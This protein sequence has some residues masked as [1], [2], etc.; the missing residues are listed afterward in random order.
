MAQIAP[1]PSLRSGTESSARGCRPKRIKDMYFGATDANNEFIDAESDLF[2]SFFCLYPGFNL[3]DI[4]SGRRYLIHGSKGSGKT[5]LLRYTE[6][7]AREKSCQTRFIKYKRQISSSEKQQMAQAFIERKATSDEVVTETQ[8]HKKDSSQNYVLGW[9]LYLI[10]TIIYMALDCGVSPFDE[11]AGEWA[12]LV[13]LLREIYGTNGK[14]S[15]QKLLP[16]ITRGQVTLGPKFAKLDIVFGDGTAPQEIRA[17]FAGLAE[18]IISLYRS[19]SRNRD[20]LPMYLFI[21]EV[22]LSYGKKKEYERDVRFIG[23]MIE[24]VYTLND[25]AREN[26]FPVHI[27][28]ALREE[29]IR[30]VT[31]VGR[32]LNKA[33]EDRG[34]KINWRRGHDEEDSPLLTVL[35]RRI[36]SNLDPD[37]SRATNIWKSFFPPQVNGIPIK[38]YILDQTWSNPR[39]IVR[40]LSLLKDASGESSVFSEQ[41]FLSIRKEYA[42]L[43]WSEI[44]EEI[45]A[46]KSST[47][48]EGLRRILYGIELPFTLS[49]FIQKMNFEAGRYSSAERVKNETK[50]AETLELLFRYGIVGNVPD[51]NTNRGRSRF[52]SYGETEPEMD[53]LFSVHYPLRT[54]FDSRR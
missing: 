15:V 50:P 54:K 19:L 51:P 48:I 30:S 49:D 39:D 31:N 46:A 41:A 17:P 13:D 40:L 2:R 22:E 8:P 3:E 6:L 7:E 21:D 10:K 35:E 45:S 34:I 23:D 29:V 4:L 25:V 18:Y 26:G 53:G 47:Y 36:T 27:I 1:N 9:Q 20:S 38:R 42:E 52:I 33:I 44:S 5:M 12:E 11:T 14:Q 32:E 28:L 24:S 16:K 43:S 37:D